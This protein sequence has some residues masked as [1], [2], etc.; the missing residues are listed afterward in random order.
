MFMN[1]KLIFN[2][3]IFIDDFLLIKKSIRHTPLKFNNLNTSYFKTFFEIFN[4]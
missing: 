3:D 1:N 2:N 4:I